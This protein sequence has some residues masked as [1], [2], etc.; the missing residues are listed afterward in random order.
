MKNLFFLF[1]RYFWI[2][3]FLLCF[4]VESQEFIPNYFDYLSDNL[5]LMHPAGA[6]IGSTGKLRAFHRIQWVG[7]KGAPTLSSVSFHNRFTNKSAVGVALFMDKNG[8]FSQRGGFLTYAYHLNLSD[9]NRFFRQLSF[10]V[11]TGFAQ[12]QIN[13]TS[14]INTDNDP[15]FTGGIVSQ[16][17]SSA[18]FGMAYH[19]A[20]F[21]GYLTLKNLFVTKPFKQKI[22]NS[23][24]GLLKS[25][26]LLGYY[27][28]ENQLIQYEPSMMFSYDVFYQKVTI[29]TNFKFYKPMNNSLMWMVF[30]Y[31][32]DT[33]KGKNNTHYISPIFGINY[34]RFMFSYNYTEVTNDTSRVSTG[35]FHQF[36][37]GVDLFFKDKRMSACPNINAAYLNYY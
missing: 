32:F 31:R 15:L 7:V 9:D 22:Y 25:F 33:V 23:F 13:Q 17:F 12:T 14:F 28:G 35:G 30:S 34:Q 24:G 21:Y 29:D 5:Y 1:N 26:L 8:Y 20:G 36:T 11:S 19:H 37:I 10:A 18:D 16:K 4:R 6:G 2:V 27:F 3:F